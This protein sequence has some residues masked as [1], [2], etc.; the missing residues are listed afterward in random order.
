MTDW[1][2]PPLLTLVYGLGDCD[3]MAVLLIS[4]MKRAGVNA[5]LCDADTDLDGYP[6]HLTVRYNNLIYEPTCSDCGFNPSPSYAEDWDVFCSPPDLYLMETE[7]NNQNEYEPSQQN[8]NTILMVIGWKTSPEVLKASILLS[9]TLIDKGYEVKASTDIDYPN[10]LNR[11]YTIYSIGDPCVNDLS[12]ILLNMDC[13]SW[14]NLVHVP[15]FYGSFEGNNW[16]ILSGNNDQQ[17]LE[18]LFQVIDD[19]ETGKY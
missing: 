4:L 14:Q 19:I 3:D 11:G 17:T 7:E 18:V 15:E 9:S 10:Y 8:S 16:V 5:E 1:V 13:S 2:N 12:A 6:D